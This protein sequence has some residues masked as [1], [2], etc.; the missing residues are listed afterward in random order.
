VDRVGELVE[1]ARARE[2]RVQPQLVEALHD[3]LKAQTKELA[4]VGKEAVDELKKAV[5]DEL[6]KEL[7]AKI[8]RKCEVFVERGLDEGSG[9]KRRMLDDLLREDLADAVLKTA[10]PLAIKV[11]LENY[12]PVEEQ[13]REHFG[14]QRDPLG[15]ARE[16]IVDAHGTSIRRADKARRGRV[17]SEVTSVLDAMPKVSV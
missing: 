2:T 17:L 6:Y 13:V 11:L 5:R 7:E 9:V 10:R 15:A 12:H 3:Q 14:E 4:S 1:W 8:R 16:A